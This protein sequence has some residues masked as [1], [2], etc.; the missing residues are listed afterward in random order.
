MSDDP[1]PLPEKYSLWIRNLVLQ[2][3]NK[4]AEKRPDIYEIIKIPQI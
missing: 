4:D 1:Q 2:M 3:L